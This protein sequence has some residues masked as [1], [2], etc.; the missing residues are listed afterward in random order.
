[1]STAGR[2]ADAV[3]RI[4]VIFLFAELLL[5]LRLLL[6]LLLLLSLLHVVNYRLAG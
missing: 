6:L 4:A 5:L 2:L 3:R 1:L